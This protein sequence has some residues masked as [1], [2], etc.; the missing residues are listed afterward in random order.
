MTAL[1]RDQYLCQT[2]F[3][4]GDLHVEKLIPHMS[5]KE[6]NYA[7]Y[8]IL[9][10]WAGLPI[11]YDQVSRES[12]KIHNFLTNPFEI[13]FDKYIGVA[14]VIIL[15]CKYRSNTKSNQYYEYLIFVKKEIMDYHK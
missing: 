2:G 14:Q 1:N 10:S 8:L 4:V 5:E 13:S 6:R 7:T 12:I 15:M 3:K 11:I 9:A